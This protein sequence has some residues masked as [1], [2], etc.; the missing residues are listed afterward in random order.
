MGYEED[1]YAEARSWTRTM[2][3]SSSRSRRAYRSFRAG[4]VRAPPPR[5]SPH[6]ELERS[7]PAAYVVPRPRHL[8]ARRTSRLSWLDHKND[9]ECMRRV[10]LASVAPVHTAA[11]RHSSLK[12]SRT[13]KRNAG[14]NGE[15]QRRGSPPDT[16]RYICVPAIFRSQHTRM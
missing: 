9:L 3:S 7:H 11:H 15:R 10:D 13:P 5:L 14:D 6:L 8:R 4:S 12:D 1:G 16:G 2:R